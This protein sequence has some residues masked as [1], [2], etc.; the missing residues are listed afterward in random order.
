[1]LLIITLLIIF[2]ICISICFIDSK[3]WH[4]DL[5]EI[6]GSILGLLIGLALFFAIL[7]AF[8][9]Q[10]MAP[11]TQAEFVTKYNTLQNKVEHINEYNI[12]EVK[13]EVNEWN[14]K[15]LYE[16]Y[17]Q[18]SPWISIYHTNKL[19]DVNYLEVK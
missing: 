14:S 13:E 15:L 5:L 18:Q 6:I 17:A 1:M 16:Y 10:C 4:T 11:H 7:I 19:D 8:I 3:Y 12:C 2:I 9:S